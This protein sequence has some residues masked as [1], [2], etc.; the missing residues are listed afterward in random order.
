MLLEKSKIYKENNPEKRRNTCN[1]W[2]HRNKETVLEKQS[3][4]FECE[5]GSII[6][7]GDKSRHFKSKKHLN[8]ISNK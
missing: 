7:C 2:Y 3:K 4:R 1:E 6:C 8:F 5:C